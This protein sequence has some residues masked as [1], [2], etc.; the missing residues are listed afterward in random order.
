VVAAIAALLVLRPAPTDAQGMSPVADVD[1]A[2]YPLRLG[3]LLLSPAINLSQIGVD[4]NILV[5]PDDPKEDFVA[6]VAPDVGFYLRPRY[7]RLT[8]S[9][10]AGF[11]YFKTYDEEGYVAGNVRGR[12]DV[13][14][15]RIRPYLGAGRTDTRDRPNKEIDARARHVDTEVGGGLGFEI[16]PA[17][18]VYGSA[19]RTA[20]RYQAG[21]EFSGVPLDE[22][23]NRSSDFYD[24]GIRLALTPLTT[25]AV[26]GEVSHDDFD[27][28]SSRDSTSQSGLAEFTFA[29][30]AII[31]GSARLGIRHF[32]PD[33]AALESFTGVTAAVAIAWPI[34]DRGLFNLGVLRDVQYSYDQSEGYYVDST[35]DL[36]YT[37]RI[38][39][40]VDLQGRTALGRLNY[41]PGDAGG[42]R[43][44]GLK[45]LSGGVGYNF[46]SRSRA[47]LTLEWSRRSSDERPDR[48]YDRTRVF[49]S[50]N[51]TF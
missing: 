46:P 2:S 42:D 31:R 40:A 50:W 38:L 10:G 1:P 33:D 24:A 3:P 14:L 30:D 12:A 29:A 32:N 23:M 13:L 15:N 41:G 22:A 45:I 44:D 20:T 51:Y 48:R 26:F 8:G 21:Q 16:S 27:H 34:L 17:S 11:N 28:E 49:G 47:G 6:T 39:G 7:L 4:T 43:V 5:E 18:L 37:H 35:L 36:T 9:V 25:L 19:T